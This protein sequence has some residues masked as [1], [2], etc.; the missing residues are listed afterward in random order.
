ML[1]RLAICTRRSRVFYPNFVQY[2]VLCYLGFYAKILSRKGGD[3]TERGKIKY[4]NKNN[5]KG[6]NNMIMTNKLADALLD[7]L[8][9]VAISAHG[10]YSKEGISEE[11][12]Q[13]YA[14]YARAKATGILSEW[15]TLMGEEWLIEGD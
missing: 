11:K 5:R 7:V 3:K 12:M 4:Y 1:I 10:G 2:Y 9:C 13:K 6:A 8:I 15:E 14:N